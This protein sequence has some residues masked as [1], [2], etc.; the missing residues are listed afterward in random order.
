MSINDSHITTTNEI[1]NSFISSQG[2]Q[3]IHLYYSVVTGVPF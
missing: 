2:I 3:Y 1:E